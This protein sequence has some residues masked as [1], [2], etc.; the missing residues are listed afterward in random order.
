ELHA[1]EVAYTDDERQ[2]HRWLQQYTTLRQQNHT[3]NVE[4]TATEFVLK[5]LKKR[6]LSSPAAFLATLQQHQQS[7]T[8]AT[9][10]AQQRSL[11]R[12]GVGIL[13][14]MID[15][16][17]ETYGDDAI[18]ETATDEALHTT[19]SLFRPLTED[20]QTLL[21]QM[22]RWADETA[23]R[24]DRKAQTLLTWLR[25]HLFSA[26]QWTDERVIIFTEYRATQ[27]WLQALFAAEGITE[28]DRLL[29]LYGG[30]ADE[31]REQVK[32][33]FQAAPEDSRVRVLLATDAASEGIDLQ[34]H[35]HRLIHYEI[36]WNPNRMEQRNGRIDRHGQPHTPYIYHFAPQ[37]YSDETIDRDA[38]VGNLEGDLEFLMRA[39]QKVEQIR[40]DLGKVGPVIADQVTEAML[41]Q[42]TRLDTVAAERQAA[43]VRQMLKFERNLREHIQKLADQVQESRRTLH[44]TPEHIQSVVQVALNLAGQP[45]LEPAAL[46]G[47]WPDPTGERR[48]SP[49]FWLPPLR[50]SWGRVCARGWNTPTPARYARLPLTT[51]WSR[52]AMMWCWCISIIGWCRWRCACCGLRYGAAP[53]QRSCIAWLPR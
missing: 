27:K 46:P 24:P 50:G 48:S 4:R 33:A 23:R 39:V 6:L 28:G 37:G 11:R 51:A 20:E 30:M 14:A 13:R 49:V 22:L 18:Y 47:V 38:P 45:L 21:T 35:C 17:D 10:P 15:E 2:A 29:T 41:G 3:D 7:L 44:L 52:G 42:R 19:T 5:L 40:E 31:H 34:R 12:P 1:L 53:T 43:P 8:N 25:Q 26:G 16:V 9:R 36:P 32:A